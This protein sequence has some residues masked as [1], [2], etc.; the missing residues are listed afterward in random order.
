MP[1]A[2][3]KAKP[4]KVDRLID[5]DGALWQKCKQKTCQR[6]CPVDTFAPRAGENKLAL[7]LQAA[8]LYQQTR[9]VAARVTVVQH[10]TTTCDRCRET[11]KRSRSNP[12][13]KQGKCRAYWYELKKTTFHTCVDCGATRAVEADNIVSDADRA[14]LFA[15]GMVSVPEHH[16][17]SDYMWWSRPAHGRVEGM[18]REAKVCVSRCKMCHSLQPTSDSA[19]RVD[20]DTLPPVVDN[21]SAVDEKMYE[22]RRK[23]KYRWPR[24][25]YV[26]RL[27]CIVGQCENL[28][29]PRDGPSGGQC[30][31]G[32]EQAYDW[33][34]VN[35]AAKRASISE[36]CHDLPVNMLEDDWKREIHNELERGECRLLCRNC[37]HLKTHHGMV[38]V[39]E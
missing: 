38:P 28:N 5:R 1:R 39:Y 20:P 16:K 27:K 18:K 22:K 24:Y 19:K 14:V 29:C 33:E 8:A 30:I 13:S 21:E 32:F 12:N 23:A 15:K 37:H 9:S 25:L 3:K 7:F 2:P 36:L 4:P 26:D 34:H 31:L 11:N 10:V 6:T 35:A 17:L